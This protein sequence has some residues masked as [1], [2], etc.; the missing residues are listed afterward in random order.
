MV[1]SRRH[2]VQLRRAVRSTW[3][4]AACLCAAASTW[5]SATPWGR[6]MA[7][8]S[9]SALVVRLH[10]HRPDQRRQRR[11]VSRAI[12]INEISELL[13]SR[14]SN[15]ANYFRCH[16]RRRGDRLLLVA[17]TQGHSRIERQGAAHH[18]DH[19]RDGG[20]VPDLVPADAPHARS[21]PDSA[22]ADCLPIC[23]SRE[24]AWAGCSGT[25]ADDSGGRHDH[26][27]R[28]L[29]SVDERIRNACAGVSRN[30]LSEAEEP[31]DHRQI[32]SASMPLSARA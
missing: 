13:H 11:P 30:R 25:S 22:R 26:R 32:W 7:R 19:D 31:E 28:P 17:A 20:D 6:S 16:V 5:S 2:A 3:K 29:A 27:L 9:V 4:A 14:L 12:C 23:N 15:S 8:L 21:R 1:H 24:E 18:A 10:P